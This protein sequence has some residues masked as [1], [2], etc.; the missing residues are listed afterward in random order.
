MPKRAPPEQLNLAA[1]KAQAD[2]ELADAEVTEDQLA[3]SN[4]PQLEQA[5][6]D[7]QAAAAH[8]DTAPGE[9]R[10]TEAEVLGQSKAEAKA[11][12]TSGIAGM[13]GAKGAALAK[14][15]ADKGKAKS[16]D[17]AKRAEV[18]AKI[19]Q[20]FTSTETEV[21]TILDGIDPLVEKEF[22]AGEARARAAFESYVAAKMSAYKKDR[23]GG[24]L[25][26]LRWAKDKLFGMPAKVNEFYTAG[27]ELYL[28]QVDGVISRVAE[29][30][31]SNLTAAKQR[32]A[33]GRSEI[34]TYVKSLPKDLQKVGADASKEIGERF[35]QLE[36][37][38]DEKQNAVVDTLAT[39][40][41]EA[42]KGLDER[43]EALQ[44]ENKGLVDK[45]IDGIKAVLN[46][47]RE[48]DAML[49]NVL[50]RAAGVVGQIIKNPIG[51]LGN[52]VAGIKGG[53]LKFAD[54][55]LG[56]L[57]KGL[58]SWLFGA[59]AEGGVELPDSFD[60]KGIIKLLA[61]I[62]GLTWAN[63]RNRLVKQIGEKAMGAVEKGVE[64]FSV[65]A[66]HGVSGLW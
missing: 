57:R 21:K 9:F 2:S 31:G 45:A 39:K 1:G 36:S 8:A 41:V 7:K 63:I 43:I 51:F 13:Q 46:T 24:W 28:A 49:K 20:I 15:V 19:E 62:F 44:A 26:G 56:H 55:I 29:I 65:L 30:V 61:S 59:L 47:I 33:T 58:M 10:K 4:E 53:I 32:I 60:V 11:T 64:I 42:R 6:S 66:T 16:K 18:T 52:L 23:Y 14:L 27:R 40:Y 12:T 38:V 35:S 3:N 17:E 37:E 22:N 50:A 54:N 5:L 34:T 48:L 25:G